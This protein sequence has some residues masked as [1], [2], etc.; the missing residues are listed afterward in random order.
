MAER[1]PKD[2]E[3]MIHLPWGYAEETLEGLIEQAQQKWFGTDFK[4]VL[5]SATR[6]QTSGCGCCAA[7]WSDYTSF[8]VLERKK[9]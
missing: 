8:I 4:D 5:V 6:I 9:K 2:T 7:D 3:D 1:W